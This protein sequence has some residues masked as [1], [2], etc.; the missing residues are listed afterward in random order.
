MVE[1]GVEEL[2][3]VSEE[4]ARL[5]SALIVSPRLVVAALLLF[6]AS[7]GSLVPLESR[8]EA[9]L[10]VVL[11]VELVVEEAPVRAASSVS[12]VLFALLPS[13]GLLIELT[14]GDERDAS[15]SVARQVCE[16]PAGVLC[17]VV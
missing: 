13:A 12:I 6:A 17:C 4:P 16:P 10:R 14:P 1:L 5:R 8:E 7:V 9:L 2:A 11:P 15:T 3:V